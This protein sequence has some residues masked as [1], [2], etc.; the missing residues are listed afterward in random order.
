MITILEAQP[1]Y[2]GTSIASN[3]EDKADIIKKAPIKSNLNFFVVL[4]CPGKNK[5]L[6]II[7]KSP[8]GKIIKKM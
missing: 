3:M 4:T 8:N 1:I 7:K 5:M 6:K 2:L